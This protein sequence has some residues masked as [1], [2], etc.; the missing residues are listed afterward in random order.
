MIIN[1][2]AKISPNKPRTFDARVRDMTI[3]NGFMLMHLLIIIGL[4][5]LDSIVWAIIMLARVNI[6]LRMLILK[7]TRTAGIPPM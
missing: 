6:P 1:G 5:I 3:K 7:P 2:T 4:I